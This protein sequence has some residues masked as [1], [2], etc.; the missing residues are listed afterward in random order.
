MYFQEVVKTLQKYWA[1]K[2]CNI[3][4][5]YDT[6]VGAGTFHP[7]TVFR[8]IGPNAWKCTYVQPSRRPTDG[9]FGDNPNRVQRHHQ[10]QV[11]MKPAPDNIQSLYLESL[12]L[13]GLSQKTHDIRF[14][15]DDWESPTLG[16]SGLGWEVW[17][18]GMEAT[19]FTYFQQMGGIKCDPIT[20]ELAYGL[21]RLVMYVQNIDDMY[22]IAWNATTKY[23]DIFKASEY[24]FSCYN[25]NFANTSHIRTQIEFLEEECHELI[26]N[27]LSLPAYDLCLKI[28]HLFNLLDSRKA[29]SQSERA[30]IIL[31]IRGLVS[32]CCKTY[33]ENTSTNTYKE[34]L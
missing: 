4:Y 29:I 7:E 27:G 23:R 28:S 19:Q 24:E 15:E 32:L 8:S 26:N 20:V 11:I 22:D 1:Q 21:E 13:I 5:P 30:S 33:L 17:C 16:A 6:E 12:E 25:F 10:L 31:K 9:R 3:F 18:D 2:G 14:V 34:A